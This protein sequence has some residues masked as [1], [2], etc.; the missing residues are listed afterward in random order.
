MTAIECADKCLLC[1]NGGKP[2]YE[3]VRDFA[4]G[5][6]AE[7]AFS[8]CSACGLAWLS[9]RPERPA[10]GAFYRQY[11][12]HSL[13]AAARPDSGRRFLGGFRDVVRQS[14][15]SG[16]Y[17][18]PSELG[19][20]WRLCGKS[21]GHSRFL[22]E[23]ATNNLKELF[24]S[25]RKD[26][27]L[28]DIGCARGD[29]LAAMKAF[30]WRVLGVEQDGVSAAL[31]RERGLEVI[32]SPLESAGLPDNNADH[33][34]MNHALEHFY[35]PLHALR[36]CHA[37][38]K[39]GGSMAVYVPNVSSLGHAIFGRCWVPLD[40]PRHLYMFSAASLRKAFCLAGFSRV[41]VWTS[42]L[43]AQSVYDNSSLLRKAGR[44]EGKEASPA[45]G[46]KIFSLAEKTLCAA[47]LPLGED[48]A[49]IAVK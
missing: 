47:G 19:A 15:I 44:T 24:P 39:P 40:P 45:S 18:Y 30:G 4:F 2:L 25:Y 3:A 34:T 1:G 38:L 41:K 35:D 32:N 6:D 20:S 23:M 10:M 5:G 48:V 12:T 27:L 17:G 21:L 8:K 13:P 46:R 11:Y 7:F 14:I 33:I 43:L 22:R 37:A 28:I 16:Y 42:P 29:F 36:L 31:A 9:K 26:G 49:A